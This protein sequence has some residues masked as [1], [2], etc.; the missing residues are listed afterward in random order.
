MTSAQHAPKGKF[1]HGVVALC[2]D[3]HAIAIDHSVNSTAFKVQ[4]GGAYEMEPYIPLF[5]AIEWERFSYFLQDG[6]YTLMLDS[7]DGSC[8]PTYYAAM[9]VNDTVRQLV[10]PAALEMRLVRGQPGIT[11][12]PR[13][14]VSV[15]SLLDEKPDLIAAV[16]V[17]GKFLTITLHVQA[18]FA[19]TSLL[20]QIPR[21]D[22]LEKEQGALWNDRLAYTP[23]FSLKCDASAHLKV[24]LMT[25]KSHFFFL[26]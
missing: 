1:Y 5:S 17:D 9:D 13:K 8:P 12:P 24:S 6:E 20:M 15:R 23:G 10:I 14:Y 11:M 18:D 22:W 19:G 4:L 3:T 21:A 2:F 7:V 26:A 25:A 16:P